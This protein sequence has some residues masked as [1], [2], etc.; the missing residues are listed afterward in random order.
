MRGFEEVRDRTAEIV[1]SYGERIGAVS[2]IIEKS[3][4]ML[5]ESRHTSRA[6]QNQLKETLAKVESLRKKDFDALVTPILFYQERREQEIKEF[7][8][9]FLKNQRE[10]ACQLKRVIQ[11]GIF[12]KVPELEKTLGE[13]IQDAKEHLVGFCKEQTLIGEKMEYLFQKKETLTSKE[14]KGVLEILQ[15]E[16][17]FS[18][19]IKMQA[20]ANKGGFLWD[21]RKT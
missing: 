3:L 8:N 9:S 2:D 19:E 12:S 20:V 17:G 18:E 16:L 10:L 21:S 11:A 4:K 7:L 15:R 13:T 14:F 6:V 5:D 1:A